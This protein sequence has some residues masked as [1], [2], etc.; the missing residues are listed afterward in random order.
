MS[1]LAGSPESRDQAGDQGDQE[2]LAG[3]RF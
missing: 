1:L 3:Q 2:Y